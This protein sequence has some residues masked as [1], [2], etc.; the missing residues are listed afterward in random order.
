MV[1]DV[2][3]EGPKFETPLHLYLSGRAFR[4]SKTIIRI[5]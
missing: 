2:G 1:S 5:G 4:R 3:K